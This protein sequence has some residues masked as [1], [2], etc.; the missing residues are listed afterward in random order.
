MGGHSRAVRRL[1]IALLAVVLVAAYAR[2]QDPTVP[3]DEATS[4][5]AKATT[6][7]AAAAVTTTT[8]SPPAVAPAQPA[9]ATCPAVPARRA[10]DPSRPSYV[11]DLTV[12]L[13][14]NA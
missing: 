14:A 2:D 12:D 13:D 10:P 3:V 11:L 8:S 4:T 9:T 7:V 6:T 5:S 1:A